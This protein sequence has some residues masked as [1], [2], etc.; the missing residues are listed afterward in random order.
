M[1]RKIFKG[2]GVSKHFWYSQLIN[3]ALAALEDV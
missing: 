3:I 1:E 2:V